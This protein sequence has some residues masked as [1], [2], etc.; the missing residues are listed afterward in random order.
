MC[1]HR[2]KYDGP[3]VQE[4]R[5]PPAEEL[6]AR[7]KVSVLATSFDVILCDILPDLA[8][9]W[10]RAFAPYPEVAVQRGD[11]LEVEADAYVSPANS[12]GMMD[13]GL[14]AVLKERFPDIESQVQGAIAAVGRLLPVGQA[15]VVET[16]D[17]DVPYL[18]CAPTMEVPS[19]VGH[20]SNAF[21]AMLALLSAIEQFNTENGDAIGSVVIPG[22]CT[23]VGDMEPETAALQMARAYAE[24]RNP[25]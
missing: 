14:D 5:Q 18:I 12:Y 11:L 15:L 9:A 17:P 16:G 2:R 24:W 23:G 19:R 21:R 6:C 3:T 1:G 8:L 20:T 7:G 13:G 4:R 25:L 22:L 10:Q